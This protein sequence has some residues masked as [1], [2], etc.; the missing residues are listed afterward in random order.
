VSRWV[1]TKEGSFACRNVGK[2]GIEHEFEVEDED[3]FRN[4]LRGGRA[5]SHLNVDLR[6]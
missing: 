2:G 1:A 3:D 4:D 5:L 6:Y